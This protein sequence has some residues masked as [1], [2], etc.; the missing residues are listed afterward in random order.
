MI[1]DAEITRIRYKYR[2]LILEGKISIP[3]RDAVRLIG[4]DSAYRLYF[5]AGGSRRGK[6]KR[7]TG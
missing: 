1:N 4:P 3:Y 6:K 5:T 7:R 2:R